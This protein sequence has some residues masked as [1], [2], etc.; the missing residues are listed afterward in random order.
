[1]LLINQCVPELWG[2]PT[3]MS[4]IGGP[5]LGRVALLAMPSTKSTPVLPSNRGLEPPQ[6]GTS[7]G[8]ISPEKWILVFSASKLQMEKEC[9][10]KIIY[11]E[12]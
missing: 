9:V 12:I 10:S 4:G 7:N 11:G 3:C 8:G 1:M 5:I 6:G 2:Q